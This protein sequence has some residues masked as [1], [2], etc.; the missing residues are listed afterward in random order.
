MDAKGRKIPGKSAICIHCGHS[1]PLAMHRRLTNEGLGR[2]TLLLVA[3]VDERVGKAY[4]LP[5]DK[6]VNALTEVGR[7]LAQEPAF[8]PILSAI[9]DEGIAPGN[10]NIVGPSIYGCK[11]Y[12]D[13]MC[14][15]QALSFARMSR[16]LNELAGEMSNVGISPDYVRALTGFAASQIVRKIRYSTRCV[17]LHFTRQCVTDIFLNEGSI[18]YSYDF[19]ET[20]LGGG[21]GSWSSLC[22]SGMQN[23]RSLVSDTKGRAAQVHRASAT[24]I[25]LADQ[26]ISAV[27][28][29]PPYDEMI[30]YADSSDIFYVWL[31]RALFNTWPEMI[32]T[33]DRNGTQEK[34][35]EIIV[36]RVRG[37]APLEH[38]TREHYD[39][40]I[41]EAFREMRRVIRAD[42]VVTIVFGHGEPEV[43]QR[44]LTAISSAGLIMTGSWPANTEFGGT[45]GKAN[46][47]TTLTMSCR[48]AP[49]DRP[50]GRKGTVEAEIKAEITRRYP[51]WERWG[52]A[53]ADMLMAASGP[54]MEVVGRYSG[55][56]DAR[57]NPVD[58][59]TFLP[60]ARAAVQDAMAVKINDQ[61]LEVFDARTRFALWWVRLYGRQL[62]AKSELRW[63]TLASALEIGQVRDLVPDSGS[64]VQFVSSAA[65]STAIEAE[66]P[67][68][69]VALALAR[70]SE[71]GL[72]AMGQLLASAE[73]D[74]D[75]SYLWAAIQFL[76]DRLPDN[77]PDA[78]A[79]AR[80]LRTR[81]SIG[82][83]LNAANAANKAAEQHV[84]YAEAQLKLM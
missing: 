67:T 15:R 41:A 6:E 38:R 48:P 2:D 52:L 57:G 60:L 46:I 47:T 18:T 39:S 33:S 84:Q 64:G 23:L 42:G 82:T 17:S 55:V 11:T 56:L 44:L 5:T 10:N 69:D 1:H 22:N 68:I 13:L 70:V 9:P 59:Y 61:P 32:V 50:V 58:I 40:K 3:D 63:Q 53:P 73:R 83:A 62:Q 43:W 65:F 27:V 12:G 24:S 35:D 21:P 75:D 30:A 19:L 25:A 16:A 8:S 36:K 76:A 31:K 80:V 77:D 71:D 7:A 26:T 74:A 29:D 20:G 72:E 49:P 37:E 79:F 54:A 51:D 45:Q 4:R 78:V 34:A 28:T 66:S 14:D 81:T